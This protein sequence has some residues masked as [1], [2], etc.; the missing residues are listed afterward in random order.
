MYTLPVTCR[1]PGITLPGSMVALLKSMRT[2]IGT[3]EPP[4]ATE[5]SV[6]DVGVT[7]LSH[8]VIEPVL[9]VIV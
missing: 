7:M 5:L 2:V 8:G 6:P 3:S 9:F 4:V 1:M